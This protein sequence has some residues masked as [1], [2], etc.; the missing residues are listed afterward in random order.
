M[1]RTIEMVQGWNCKWCH[2]SCHQCSVA[3]AFHV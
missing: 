3:Y 2:S 1:H